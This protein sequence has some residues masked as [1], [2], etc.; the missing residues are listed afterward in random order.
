MELNGKVALVTGSARGIGK[1]IALKFAQEGA[2]VALND[3][4]DESL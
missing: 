3:I 1:A 2:R 4:N